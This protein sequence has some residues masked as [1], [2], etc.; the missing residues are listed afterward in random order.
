M[1]RLNTLKIV[2]EAKVDGPTDEMRS[3]SAPEVEQTELI[4]S[5]SDL[6]KLNL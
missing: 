3:L 5:L 4:K 6:T 2:P 1:T